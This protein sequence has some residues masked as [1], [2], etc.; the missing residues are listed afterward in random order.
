MAL[1]ELAELP[2]FPGADGDHE[3][4]V[5]G[6]FHGVGQANQDGPGVNSELGERDR[7]H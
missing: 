5:G 1:K 3:F 4:M 2:D 6:G 7:G